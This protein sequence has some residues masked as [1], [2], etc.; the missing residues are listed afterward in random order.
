MNKFAM[1]IAGV[2]LCASSACASNADGGRE[3]FRHI[4][5]N[6]DRM[7]EF[8]EIEAAR[9]SL[10]DRM[11]TNHDGVLEADEVSAAGERIKAR[12][13]FQRAQL[14]NLQTQA[15][16]MDTNHDAKISRDEFAD[17][18]PD[19]L[20]QAETN[21]DRSLSLSELRALRHQ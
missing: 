20:L 5:T 9:A 11:D 8:T 15:V 21:G 2:M 1:T 7:L 4:D 17:F 19:R 6:G 14:A 13:D 3:L 16:R 10:F 18:I 12:Q